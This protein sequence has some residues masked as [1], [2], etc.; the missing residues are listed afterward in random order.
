MNSIRE[1][2]HR[3][4]KAIPSL[5]DTICRH[6]TLVREMI[7]VKVDLRGPRRAAFFRGFVRG[8]AAPAMLYSKQNSVLPADATP[9]AQHVP[10]PASRSDGIKGD[11]RRVGGH[12]KEAVRKH[13]AEH[14]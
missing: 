1:R 5:W 7:M 11:W 3:P 10:N 4:H 8:L 2:Q 14:G 12:L 6:L 13:A 9:T